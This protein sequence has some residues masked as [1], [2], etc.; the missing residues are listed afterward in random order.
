MI[1]L[2]EI[3]YSV[4]LKIWNSSVGEKPAYRS[5]NSVKYLK[6]DLTIN[7]CTEEIKKLSQ[8]ENPS[9]SDVLKVVDLIN[10]WGGRS[11]RMFYASKKGGPI[12]RQVLE[13]DLRQFDTYLEGIK[14]AKEGNVRCMDE[15]V[16]VYGIGPSFASKHS[17]FWSL[18]SD[19][20]LIIL[21]SKIAGALGSNT[22][23]ELYK[24]TSYKEVISEFM[25]KS[26]SVFG[27]KDASKVERALFAFHNNYFK[28]DNSGWKRKPFRE[29]KDL[30]IAKGLAIKLFGTSL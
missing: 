5:K 2:P 15:F 9:K 10:A 24:K 3:D 18:H 21:D 13:D 14:L 8:I 22:L 25:L 26:I 29:N 28:N 20:P 12:A 6:E 16:R 27:Q 30:D 11:G 19:S 7:Q 17:Y 23:S 1:N 4:W